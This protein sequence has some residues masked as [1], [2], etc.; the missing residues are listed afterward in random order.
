MKGTLNF[1]TTNWRQLAEATLDGDTAGRAAL[2]R[3]CEE[4]HAPLLAFLRGRG[5]SPEEAEDFTQE[6]FLELLESRAWKRASPAR[7]RF[8][9]FL[10]G[11]LMHVVGRERTRQAAAKR[12][13]GQLLASLDEL[14]EAGLELA[15]ESQAE[16]QRFD[17][18]WAQRL[19]D[20]ALTTVAASFAAE[21]WAVL[22][23]FL[24]GAGGPPSYEE[25][26]RQ[27]G[28]PLAALK[29]TVHRLRA[30]FRETLRGAVARTVSAAHEVE[31]ELAYLR[32]VLATPPG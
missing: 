25:A 29:T 19:V 12:G 28:I 31:E 16:V 5:F 10:L 7:G 18:E 8:R 30:R 4:Y 9:T 24:P 13:G 21:E 3:L 14:Q 32:R 23:G 22:V 27:L 20:S 26:A 2:Q 11:T 6:F 1:P 15:G 17:R